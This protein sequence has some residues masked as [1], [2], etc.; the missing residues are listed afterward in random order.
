MVYF[1]TKIHAGVE[2]AGGAEAAAY[3]L[4]EGE[5]GGGGGGGGEGGVQEGAGE[6]G[7]VGVVEEVAGEDV[8]G[9]GL[10]DFAG[11]CRF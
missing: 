6:R 9:W 2:V 10:V 8:W 5:C 7:G 1:F 11:G 4:S 3:V